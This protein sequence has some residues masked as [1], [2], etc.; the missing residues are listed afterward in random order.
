M[1]HCLL[2]SIARQLYLDCSSRRSDHTAESILQGVS[3][4]F[5]L[6][7]CGEFVLVLARPPLPNFLVI[8]ILLFALMS[9][10]AS[11]Q[12]Y[13]PVLSSA[14][15]FDDALQLYV[16][17]RYAEALQVLELAISLEPADSSFLHLQGDVYYELQNYEKAVGAFDMC[18]RL[19]PRD[20]SAYTNRGWSYYRLRKFDQARADWL[21]SGRLL[22]IE[23]P[24]RP[25]SGTRNR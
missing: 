10:P 19:N 4:T 9:S 24:V 25:H 14:E 8:V 12:H 15:L 7:A 1:E 2:A 18:L 16:C 5:E 20:A 23:L 11:K 17:G 3:N 21:R 6:A 22:G 13:S